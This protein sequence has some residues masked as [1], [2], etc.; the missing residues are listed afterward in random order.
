MQESV[1]LPIKKSIEQLSLFIE[2]IEKL[3]SSSFVRS[4][5]ERGSKLK[6]SCNME[7]GFLEVRKIGP[8]AEQIDAF[9]LTMRLFMQDNDNVSIRKIESLVKSLPVSSKLKDSFE[10]NRLNLN[11]RLDAPC[12]ISIN[13][14]HPSNRVVLQTI[15]Y[16]DLSH[17]N[18]RSR[19]RYLSWI[20]EPMG[21][22]F[23]EYEFIG[24]LLDFLRTLSAMAEISRR[25][26]GELMEKLEKDDKN[27]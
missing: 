3:N 19:K 15:L 18:W 4:I 10:K 25:V 22:E 9:V 8:D 20:E 7:S 5:A 12:W 14:D 11:V 24:I 21:K 1:Q 17:V 6:I 13:Q 2:K 26:I 16:G 27:E 23:V